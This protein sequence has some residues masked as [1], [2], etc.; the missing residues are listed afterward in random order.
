MNRRQFASR[1]AAG[2]ALCA[3][4]PVTASAATRRTVGD[5]RAPGGWA[6][7][8]DCARDRG[9]RFTGDGPVV[10]S[11]ELTEVIDRG[12]AGHGAQ[13][14]A[15]FAGPTDAPEGVYRL[16]AADRDLAL[17]LLPAGD[18]RMDAV[19]NLLD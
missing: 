5:C 13:F 18:G 14:I 9:M 7:A 11:F 8:E 4:G 6:C 2:A 16:T 3:L 12:R 19:F 15:R 17:H 1:L 10:A